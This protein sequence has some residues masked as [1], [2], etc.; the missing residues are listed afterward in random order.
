[1]PFVSLRAEMR[2]RE[3]ITLIGSAAAS[4]WPAMARAQ[5]GAMPLV[6]VLTG[7]GES[8]P[9]GQS[10]IAAFRRELPKLGWTEGTNLRIEIRYAA[11]ADPGRMESHATELLSLKPDT[12][13]V[14]GLRALRTILR[15][16]QNIPIVFAAITD[17]VGTGM[18]K[19][20]ARPGGNVTGFATF[21]GSPIAKVF[22][23]LKDIAPGVSR[24][25]LIHNPNLPTWTV[26]WRLLESVASSFS[27]TPIAVAVGNPSDITQ[28]IEIFSRQ[29][30]G[31]LIVP[32]DT[33]LIT[34]RDLII[35]LAARYRLPAVYTE[36]L[37]V[38]AGGLIS[39]G[40]DG[41]DN[42]RRAA[43]YIDRILRGAKPADLPV[44]QPTKFQL[45]I[46]LKT[47]KALDL[48]VPA[49]LLAT[50]D[51]VIE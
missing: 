48:V 42:Y 45:A 8:D 24:I 26:H 36:R 38:T 37:Y 25:A 17:P 39:Y 1:M 2:R 20:L 27:I 46:N 21:E 32:P 16:D 40:V 44:Q 13:L 33:T 47:A 5:P 19:S 10:L 31:G 41:T 51:E 4:A 22:Q 50:A 35:Q 6:G 3:F 28:G 34:H 43:S 30:N 12:I 18:V 15:N 29:P 11:A 49:S 23:A 7:Y 9:E 14:H